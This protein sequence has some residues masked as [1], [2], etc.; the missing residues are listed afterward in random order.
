MDYIYDDNIQD[1]SEN[2]NE[3]E[4]KIFQLKDENKQ[5]NDEVYTKKSKSKKSKNKNDKVEYQA[6]RTFTIGN[7]SMKKGQ[8][9][10]FDK[11]D[12]K[13]L[14]KVKGFVNELT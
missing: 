12:I 9:K 2:K 13:L 1:N 3:E 4:N 6:L 5:D 10:K 14:D 7:I 11:D 8:I